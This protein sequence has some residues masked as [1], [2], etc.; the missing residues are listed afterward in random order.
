MLG[1]ELCVD[2]RDLFAGWTPCCIEVCDEVGVGGKEGAEVERGLDFC[3][4]G[5][6]LMYVWCCGDGCWM[7]LGFSV[8]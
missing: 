7:V 8:L 3:R 5:Y 1:G 2:R 6:A 4:H